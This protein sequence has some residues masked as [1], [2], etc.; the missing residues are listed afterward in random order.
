MSNQDYSKVVVDD[1][2]IMEILQDEPFVAL[3][4]RDLIEV[5]KEIVQSPL[6][7]PFQKDHITWLHHVTYGHGLYKQLKLQSFHGINFRI[8]CKGKEQSQV[9]S[10]I[11]KDKGTQ[12]LQSPKHINTPKSQ[13]C[14]ACY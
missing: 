14:V 6:L 13:F 3:K 2:G 4:K 5:L 8:L 9:P 11:Y 10:Q 1:V 12:V 7:G